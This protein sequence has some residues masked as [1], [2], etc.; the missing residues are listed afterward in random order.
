MM[1]SLHEQSATFERLCIHIPCYNAQNFLLGTVSRIPWAEMPKNIR[2]SVLFID[3]AST[4]GTQAEIAKASARLNAAGIPN[5]AILYQRNL[6]Y[7]GSVKSALSYAI[8]QG[9]DFLAILHADG[10]YAPEELPRLVRK[11][12]QQ[13]DIFLLFGSRLAGDPRRGGMPLY[14]YF[15]N[16]LLSSF[17][18]AVSG[19]RLSE[20][21]SGY[22]C[23]RLKFASEIPWKLFSDGFVFDN[24][25]IL[26]AHN[27]GLEI[28]EM[29]I[30]TYY[31]SE[32]SHVPIISTPLAILKNSIQ[33][34]L[35]RLG[36][37]ADRRYPS[38]T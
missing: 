26:S 29:P 37:R 22:R 12:S 10:Q 31:G 15:A 17:Q 4:D 27:C 3:N 8:D 24:E 23:Y 19:L 25:I 38:K 14:K 35:C 21:H 34:L 1:N 13:C 20:Y 36:L 11:L 28:S 6:G 9:Y 5:H 33:Y 7:G 30:S 32:V 2:T 16:H 18:N